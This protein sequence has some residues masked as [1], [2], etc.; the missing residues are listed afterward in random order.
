[1]GLQAEHPCIFD[2]QLFP[3]KAVVVLKLVDPS[4]E[5]APRFAARY[6]LTLD[7]SQAV[8]GER[9]GV[10]HRGLHTSSHVLGTQILIAMEPP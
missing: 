8:A 2:P 6:S 3:Q 5:A 4:P 9:D 1:M 10:E 7:G